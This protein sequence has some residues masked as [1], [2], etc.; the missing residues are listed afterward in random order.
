[1]SLEWIN[2]TKIGKAG[3][4]LQVYNPVMLGEKVDEVWSTNKT[5]IGA[6]V[7]PPMWTFSGLHFW[8]WGCC[9]FKLHTVQP[10]NCIYSWTCGTGQPQL[11]LCSIFLVLYWKHFDAHYLLLVTCL[12]Y[13]SYRSATGSFPFTDLSEW[14]C[15]PPDLYLDF[16]PSFQLLC[17]FPCPLRCLWPYP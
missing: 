13:R 5:V 1:M 17:W 15:T 8:P 7:D 6:N 12:G 2:R 9:P 14:I 16:L 4:Q 11:G 10:L 3:D